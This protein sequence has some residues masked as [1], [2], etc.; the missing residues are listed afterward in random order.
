MGYRCIIPDDIP[1]V[2]WINRTTGAAKYL[3]A[4]A[5]D[6]KPGVDGWG[7]IYCN[8]EFSLA[9]P[10]TFY[11]LGGDNSSPARQILLSCQ[12][13]SNNEPANWIWRAGEELSPPRQ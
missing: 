4:F 5:S 8:G 9:N 13:P 11:C 12:V 1:V 10:D 6:N 3:G 2:Y 7:T